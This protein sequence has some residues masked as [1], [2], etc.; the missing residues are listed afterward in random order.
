[1]QNK[2]KKI[3]LKMKNKWFIGLGALLVFSFVLAACSDESTDMGSAPTVTSVITA[4]GETDA[5]NWKS[6]TSFVKGTDI[7]VGAKVDDP[8]QDIVKLGF[9]IRDG[10]ENPIPIASFSGEI[11]HHI[12]TYPYTGEVI[13]FHFSIPA[14]EQIPVGNGYTIAIYFIDSKGNKSNIKVSEPFTIT[15]K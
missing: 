3:L 7:S 10:S 14:E 6:K 5:K 2:R 1:M 11:T 9:S 8:D 13:T 15:E 4:D 12:P